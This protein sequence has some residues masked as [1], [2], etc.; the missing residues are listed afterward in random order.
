LACS[1]KEKAL[2]GGLPQRSAAKARARS[3]L[4]WRNGFVGVSVVTSRYFSGAAGMEM[5]QLS[6]PR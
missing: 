2:S 6:Y 1:R 5:V 3:Q 4:P